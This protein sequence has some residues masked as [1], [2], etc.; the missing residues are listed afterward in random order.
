MISAYGVNALVKQSPFRAKAASLA[1]LATLAC[2]V[3]ASYFF[4]SNGLSIRWKIVLATLVVVGLLTR[5]VSSFRAASLVAALIALGAYI[6]FPLI[7]RQ[8]SN[9]VATTHLIDKVSAAVAPDS[10]FAMAA[11]GAPFLPPNLNGIF[12]VASIHSYDSISS[13]RYQALIRELG[14]ENQTYGRLN[15]M[16]SPDYDSLAFWM[17]NISLIL[18]P[19]TLNHPNL[20]N[21]GDEGALH[22][23]RVIS[24][25]GCCIQMALPDQTRSDGIELVDRKQILSDRPSKT[26]DKGDLLEF[27]VQGE[28]NSVLVLSQQYH[29][30]W[31]ATVRTISG[32]TTA[33]TVPVNGVFQGVALPAGTQT[34]R[35][36][37]LPFARFAWVAH[38]FWAMVLLF[39][40]AHAVRSATMRNRAANQDCTAR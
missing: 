14:G 20:E 8:P 37:F 27:E 3:A 40:A 39:L 16:I 22:L 21:I 7:L 38:V 23:F 6:S 30:D 26:V 19:T 34:V 25:M 4:W 9:G 17:S 13:R 5:Q 2:L 32:W 18:S 11:P 36:Q 10:R 31:Q 28:Q 29:R 33:R 15:E 12:D 35:L 24:R 1:I